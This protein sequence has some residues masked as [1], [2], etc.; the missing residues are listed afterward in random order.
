[1]KVWLRVFLLQVMVIVIA[2]SGSAIAEEV[3]THVK[4][5]G[6]SS[7]FIALTFDDGPVQ[8]ITP[9]FLSLLEK[10]QA[11]ATFFSVGKKVKQHSDITKLVIAAGHEIGNHS[12]S[13]KNLVELTTDQQKLEIQ[14]FQ[15]QVKS[16]GIKPTLFRAPFLKK[17]DSVKQLLIDNQLL[18][19]SASVM[20]KDAKKNVAVSAIVKKLSADIKSGDIILM[21]E[22]QH[23]LNALK[24]LLPL[25]Q[26]HGYQFVTVS[27]LIALSKVTE[28]KSFKFERLNFL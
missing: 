4:V 23:T 16:L 1:M 22:R 5:K 15:Q 3:L 13:H 28:G 6:H 27:Q 19:V 25:W 9:Q 17:S 10:Y 8:G 11:K 7:K 20:A 2:C 26:E 24:I 12:W 21:H 18:L 14:Q